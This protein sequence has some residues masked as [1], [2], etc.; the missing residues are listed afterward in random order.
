MTNSLL[1]SG[2]KDN[3]VKAIEHIKSK[4]MYSELIE[5]QGRG[6]LLLLLLEQVW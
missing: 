5:F 1:G 2:N 6:L 3:L 4:Y